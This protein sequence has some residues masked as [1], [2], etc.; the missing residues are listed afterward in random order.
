MIEPAEDDESEPD[1]SWINQPLDT[2]A[3]A[4]SRMDIDEKKPTNDNMVAIK[5]EAKD[6]D[7]VLT[8]IHDVA[9][10]PGSRSPSISTPLRTPIAPSPP[11][12]SPSPRQELTQTT[13]PSS[14]KQNGTLSPSASPAVV[15]VFSPA[16]VSS[17]NDVT[18][19]PIAVHS[20]SAF[21]PVQKEDSNIFTPSYFELATERMEQ[22]RERQRR[23]E[24]S[25]GFVA[26]A[27]TVDEEVA[28]I[29]EVPTKGDVWIEDLIA[30]RGVWALMGE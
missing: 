17:A 29:L 24:D 15:K 16:N 8:D 20:P 3:L 18:I 28:Q 10:P 13:S 4:V 14:T 9:T 7:I 22:D 12:P 25:S 21:T 2:A 6:G 26:V 19:P 1:M 30:E 11:S 5:S 27:G 23:K